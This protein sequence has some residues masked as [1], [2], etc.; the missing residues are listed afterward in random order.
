[1]N[2]ETQIAE[3]DSVEKQARAIAQTFFWSVAGRHQAC[4]E[5]L[6]HT[7]GPVSNQAWLTLCFEPLL[8]GMGFFASYARNQYQGLQQA[9]F[10]N[11]LDTATRWLLSTVIFDPRHTFAPSRIAP[12]PQP[13][14]N[15]WVLTEEHEKALAPFSRWCEARQRDF[16]AQETPQSDSSG[17]ME[18]LVEKFQEEL[19][20]DLADD[21]FHCP[22]SILHVFA[23][24]IVSEAFRIRDDAGRDENTIPIDRLAR[25]G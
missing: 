12:A 21:A 15:R 25:T 5:Q 23:Q 18:A 22:E 6:Q 7:S 1:M 10:L 17:N 9:S 4:V 2:S 20:K 8:F 24:G 16:Q 14:G 13:A 3:K 11:E 19:K